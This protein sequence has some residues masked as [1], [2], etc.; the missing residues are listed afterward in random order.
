MLYKY[1]IRGFY[2][3]E[4]EQVFKRHRSRQL[5]NGIQQM[6]LRTAKHFDMPPQFW[7]SLQIDDDL[8][9]AEDELVQQIDDE[10]R[11]YTPA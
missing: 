3:K 7:L 9:V 8:D 1:V 11:V 2:D 5:P 10:G 4:T 6:M